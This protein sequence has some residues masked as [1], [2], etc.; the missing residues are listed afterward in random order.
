MEKPLIEMTE[1]DRRFMTGDQELVV[2]KGINLTIHAGE[3]VAIVGASGSGKSTLMNILGCLD[4]LSNGSYR[5][6]GQ[7]A[8]S[9]DS[10]ALAK[11]RR[12][13]FGFIFQR[14]HLMPHLNAIQNTEIPAVYSGV[15]KTRR[16]NRSHEL[17]TRLGLKER[18]DYRPGQLSGGQQ[19]RVSIARALMNGGNVILA[20]EPTGA[21]DSKSSQEMMAILKEL[22]GRGHTIILVTH[23]MNIANYAER[24]IEISDGEIIR[25]HPNPNA[26]VSKPPGLPDMPCAGTLASS[27]QANW[28]RFAEA[29]KMALLAMA[30]HRMRTL[31]TMLGIIIG[32][33]SVVSV[34]AIGQGARQK[35]INDISAMG[36]NVIDVYPGRDWGDDKAASIHTLVPSDLEAL[37]SQVY[38]DSATPG[39]SASLLLRYRNVKANALISG[40]G[41]QYFRALGM[42]MS[43][44]ASFEKSDVQRLAQVAVIDSNTRKK[45]FSASDDPVGK[46]IFIGSLPCQVIGVTKEKESPFGNNQNLNVWVPYTAAMGRLLGQQYFNSITVRIKEGMPN[47]VAEKS[48]INLLKQRHGVKDFYT[49]SSDTILKTVKKTTATL[50]LLISAIAVISLVVGGIGVMNIMLVSVSERTHEIGIRMAVG[51]RQSDI[52]QQFLIES[53]LVCLVGGVIGILLSYGVGM[54]FPF[55]V[56]I[57][58]MKFSILSIVAACLCSSLIG[59]LFGFLPARNA[60][61]LDPIEALARE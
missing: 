60:A 31:L 30:S 20:D 46:I 28:G 53:V 38:V 50:T 25:D 57:I 36:T 42:E 9:L 35:V 54:V 3:M 32:I 15:D 33:T 10:D 5:I 26:V 2:L 52:M 1:L 13:Y 41:E 45:L 51:A 19:Q 47:Q 11:L 39:T 29:L 17:L 59:V 58:V 6:N 22:H 18:C 40:V 55:F 14:Y 27:F 37:K 49:S 21:L 8:G 16:R 61:R 44:G 24:I 4:R 7:E 56:T 48:I 12:E 34:V 43:H 23:D